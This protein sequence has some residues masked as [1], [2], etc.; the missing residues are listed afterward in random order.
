MCN[1]VFTFEV[2]SFTVV[3]NVC[4]YAIRRKKVL[5]SI[6]FSLANGLDEDILNKR[7]CYPSSGLSL[8]KQ[9]FTIDP[10]NDCALAFNYIAAEW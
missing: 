5:S 10:P 7:L 6:K 8:R 9:G 2:M 1:S 4:N 3:V